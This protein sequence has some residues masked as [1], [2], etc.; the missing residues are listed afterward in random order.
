MSVLRI[1][2]DIGA[3]DVGEVHRFYQ[4]LFDLDIVWT[5]VGS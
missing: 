3:A 4:S 1:V 5:F 2:T